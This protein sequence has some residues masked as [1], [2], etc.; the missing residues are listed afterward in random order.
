MGTPSELEAPS[1]TYGH[2]WYC[3]HN[4]ASA[5][6]M[7]DLY[8]R[9]SVLPVGGAD[10][11][12][13]TIQLQPV[14]AVALCNAIQFQ[15]K[16][17]TSDVTYAFVCRE[18]DE[19]VPYMPMTHVEYIAMVSDPAYLDKLLASTREAGSVPMDQNLTYLELQ[20]AA[21][22]GLPINYLLPLSRQ[23]PL[24]P[25]DLPTGPDVGLR[26]QVRWCLPAAGRWSRLA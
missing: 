2:P 22:L 12:S 10:R 14:A 17:A 16:P 3:G 25:E 6:Q 9:Q 23:Q 15:S 24:V 20:Q 26:V 11:S 19:Q 5:C 18:H 1:D 4:S 7:L 13:L 21:R 8:W